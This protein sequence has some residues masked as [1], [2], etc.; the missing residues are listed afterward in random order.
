MMAGTDSTIRSISLFAVLTATLGLLSIGCATPF[1]AQRPSWYQPKAECQSCHER[2]VCDNGECKACQLKQARPQPCDDQTACPPHQRTSSQPKGDCEQC[3]FEQPRE[4]KKISLPDY[5]IEPPDVLL[6]EATNSLRPAHA[7]LRVGETL[8]LAVANTLPLD[9]EDDDVIR[10]FKQINGTYRIHPDG[11]VHLGPEYGSVPVK[12]LTVSEAQRA[13]ELHLKQTLRN[14]RVYVT[15]PSD[16][17][18]QHVA[19]EHL[20][21]PDG[22]IALGIYGSVY[23]SGM[24]LDSARQHIERHLAKQIFNPEVTVDVLA[25]NS[26]VYYVVTDGAGA[27]EQVFRFPC[28]GNET[29]LDAVA[30][31]NG[32]PSVSSKKHIWIARP[33]P[34]DLGYEQVLEVDWDAIV[35]GGQSKTNYQLLPGDRVYVRA[36]DLITFDTAVAKFTAPLERILGFVLLGNGTV[37]AVQNGHRTSGGG[38]F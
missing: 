20:V 38:G 37:R 9:N 21:R 16:Q 2:A 19:G 4:L 36:D 14:P 34:P 7:P 5:V 26:K 28:T 30:Q 32:L 8:Q 1:G 15:L 12:G 33:A 25:Y 6:I 27:G 18:A 23:V 35:R 13:I 29:V 31:I 17:A 10:G 11:N 22:T 24:T 3:Q